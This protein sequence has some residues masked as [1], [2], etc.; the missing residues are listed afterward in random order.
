M[1]LTPSGSLYYAATIAAILLT[2]LFYGVNS[3]LRDQIRLT[4]KPSEVPEHMTHGYSQ[5]EFIDFQKVAGARVVEGTSTRALELY[6]KRV[7]LLDIGFCVFCG[8]ASFLLWGLVERAALSARVLYLLSDHQTI[9]SVYSWIIPKICFTG[10]AFSI[11][12]GIVD[13]AEDITLIY[14]LGQLAP[15]PLQVQVASFLTVTKIVTIAGSVFGAV[16]FEILGLIF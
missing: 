10:A 12:Y 9:A 4:I 8:L 6:R 5:K 1:V 15:T 16:L 14:V 2:T 7:L 3:G 11:L 13:A